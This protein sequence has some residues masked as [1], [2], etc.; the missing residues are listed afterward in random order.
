LGRVAAHYYIQAESVAT[1]NEKLK[2]FDSLTDA[3][4]SHLICRAT[5]FENVKIRQEELNEID[6]LVKKACPLPVK[7]PV[8][9]PSG[10]SFVL[11]QAFISRAGIKSF[12]LISDTNYIA[13]NAGRVARALFE[14]CLKQNQAGPTLKLLRI[15]KGV[16]RRF[17]WFQTP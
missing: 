16:D 13:S 12:T 14:M 8:H 9:E 15:A 7:T 11:M 3:E 2:G 6:S 1:F 10:K 5:E 17:W 4:L